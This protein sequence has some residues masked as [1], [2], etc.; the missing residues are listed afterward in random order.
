MDDKSTRPP[1]AGSAKDV[2]TAQTRILIEEHLFLTE[3]IAFNYLNIP[4]CRLDE[5]QSEAA[6][7]LIRAARS[8]DSSKGKFVPF[9]SKAIRNALNTMYAKQLRMLRRFP[10]SLDDPIAW[11]ANRSPGNESDS[12]DPG[13]PA[14]SRHDVRKKVRGREAA[15]VLES[16]MKLLTPRERLAVEALQSG[17]SYPEIGAGM[18]ISKQAAHKSVRSGL[19]K[20]RKGLERMGY[21]GLASDGL[22]DSGGGD[23][24]VKHG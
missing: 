4:G 14:D 1:V 13:K 15:T 19:G 2:I 9:A 7:A 18:G 12:T 10:K 5:T 21:H 3:V 20:L 11:S 16:L 24:P 23:S 8:Y 6:Q 22:L 17:K